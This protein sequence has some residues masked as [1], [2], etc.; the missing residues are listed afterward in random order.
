VNK[1]CRG[2]INDRQKSTEPINLIFKKNLAW[3]SCGHIFL[4]FLCLYFFIQTRTEITWW[5]D[6]QY[7]HV[8]WIWKNVLKFLVGVLDCRG[9]FGGLNDFQHFSLNFCEQKRYKF[10]S[11]SSSLK[12]LTSVYVKWRTSCWYEIQDHRNIPLN[13]QV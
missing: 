11:S 13:Y 12:L 7:L 9:Y 8:D 6:I 5:F 3:T 1:H 10:V 2:Y 4:C